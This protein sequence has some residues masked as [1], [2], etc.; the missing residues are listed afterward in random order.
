[1]VV[2]GISV[3]RIWRGNIRN[4]V[5][6]PL[7]RSLFSSLSLPAFRVHG[8]SHVILTFEIS[9]VRLT[10]PSLNT[11][12]GQLKSSTAL[13]GV[14]H[15]FYGLGC[16]ISPIVA[17]KM[18]EAGLGWNSYYYVLLGWAVLNTLSLGITYHPKFMRSR[19]EDAGEIEM[20]PSHGTV[21]PSST[22]KD[23]LP[24]FSSDRIS[25]NGVSGDFSKST[26]DI[27]TGTT[28]AS[29]PVQPKRKGPLQI[30][31]T[32][33]F[34]WLVSLYIVLYLG[35]EIS[36]GGWVVEFMIQ[37]NPNPRPVPALHF[38]H[39]YSPFLLAGF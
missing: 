11:F 8:S 12:V 28:I 25:V 31:L 34:C 38:T 21:I 27:K 39:L 36:T 17:T 9:L 22:S 29:P 15:A 16:A 13:L 24:P 35:L 18:V 3:C 30:V 4:R 23:C 26:K 14:L 33:R 10:Y 32:N 1:M 37:V 6:I 2:G 7:P 5:W 19:D 20:E